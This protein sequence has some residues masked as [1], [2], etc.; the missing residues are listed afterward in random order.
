MYSENQY[1]MDFYQEIAAAMLKGYMLL[2]L[3]L[4]VWTTNETINYRETAE[5]VRDRFIHNISVI[6]DDVK[7]ETRNASRDMWACDLADYYNTGFPFA[8]GELHSTLS[9]LFFRLQ[10][11]SSKYPVSIR[12]TLTMKSI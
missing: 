3:D 6:Q 7:A 2:Q 12:A 9:S 5:L 10:I 4:M 8:P 11:P 1:L